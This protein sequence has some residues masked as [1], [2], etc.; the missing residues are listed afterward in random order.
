MKTKPHEH[1]CNALI[2]VLVIFLFLPFSLL[3]T[4]KD[5]GVDSKPSIFDAS[6]DK[7]RLAIISYDNLPAVVKRG[8]SI[9]IK[10][11]LFIIH[12]DTT[13]NKQI[14]SRE[15]IN[16]EINVGDILEIKLVGQNFNITPLISEKQALSSMQNRTWEW[17]VY[18]RSMGKDNLHLTIT[19][20]LKIDGETIPWAIANYSHDIEIINPNSFKKFE[21]FGSNYDLSQSQFI[22]LIILFVFIFVYLINIWSKKFKVFIN[23]AITRQ[24]NRAISQNFAS[25][26]I[27]ILISFFIFIFALIISHEVWS[28]FDDRTVAVTLFAGG[29]VV[30]SYFLNAGFKIYTEMRDHSLIMIREA[31]N[32]SKLAQEICDVNAYFS[33]L[34]KEGKCMDLNTVHSIKICNKE[35]FVK[36]NTVANFFEEMAIS[37]HNREA[38]E[39]LLKDY[40]LFTYLT[41][42]EGIKEGY[43]EYAQEETKII[44]PSSE[45][46]YKNMK[47][48]YEN[49]KWREKDQRTTKTIINEWIIKTC[50]FLMNFY[51]F[52]LFK[53]NKPK[54][55]ILINYFNKILYSLTLILFF[56][57]MVWFFGVHSLTNK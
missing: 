30:A 55:I 53:S 56:V 57:L 49:W 16:H 38:H 7:M 5:K 34:K 39:T 47:Y 37:I 40:F 51:K 33:I 25:A 1:L 31:R 45:K 11:E 46:I 12:T 36:I 13:K 35:L 52:D 32:N 27:L 23:L 2:F 10:L 20:F 50:D 3:A 43:V 48:L 54:L 29:T 28:T 8:E 41:F 14:Y 18:P 6:L 19:G 21:V 4:P 9:R 42:Y 26:N 17:N 22:T 44:N 15:R 24:F